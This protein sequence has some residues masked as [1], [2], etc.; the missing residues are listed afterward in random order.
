MSNVQRKPRQA[1][2][3]ERILDAAIRLADEGGIESVSMRKVG[4]AL[5]V[6][7]MSL[8][9]HVANK[10]DLLDG[11]VDLVTGEFELPDGGDWEDDVRRCAVSAHDAL[12]RHRWAAN[13][14]VAPRGIQHGRLRYM[15]WIMRRLHEAGFSPELT[16]RGYHALDSHILGFTL[17]Q[18]GH[19]MPAAADDDLIANI[20]REFPYDE[21]PYVGEHIR[22][23]LADES[24]DASVSEF[25][26]GLDLVLA[27]FNRLRA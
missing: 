12:L 25:E 26:F 3:R 8:Y 2:S 21:Y 10:D 13:L 16:Y 18:L 17:W 1:L 9:N 24:P 4:Q 22:Q 7:A 11:M 6:E 5:G 23:H 14:I 19:A 27:G 20:L 15:N